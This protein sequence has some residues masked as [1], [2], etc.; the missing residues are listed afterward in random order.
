MPTT[1]GTRAIPATVLAIYINAMSAPAANTARGRV[2]RGSRISA[3]IAETSSSPVNA[4]AICDQKLTVSQSQCGS[5]FAT[6]NF[7]SDPWP[8]HDFVD[9]PR[10]A[11][12]G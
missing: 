4:N 1:N 2:R 9:G 10:G 8:I 6:V 7:V 5:M 12:G 3:L 11:H